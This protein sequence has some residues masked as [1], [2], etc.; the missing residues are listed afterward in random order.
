[1]RTRQKELG[2]EGGD[3][4]SVAGPLPWDAEGLGGKRR[5]KLKL[6]VTAEILCSADDI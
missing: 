4:G 1:M 5:E 3:G 6:V 2:G